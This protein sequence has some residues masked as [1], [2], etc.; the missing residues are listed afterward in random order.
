MEYDELNRLKKTT[1]DPGGLA[2]VTETTRFDE[3]GNPEVTVDP[4]GQTITITFDELN[5]L[6]SKAYAFAPADTARPW[7]YTES[8]EYGYDENGN[9]QQTEEH[10]ASGSSPPDTTL[11]T[12]RAYDG[13]DR[14]TSEIQPL[15]N[16]GTSTVE[17][18]YFR[19]GTRK[20][21]KDP[22][23]S[24]TAYAYDGQNRLKT[25]TTEATGAEPQTTTYTYE[26]DDLLKTVTYPNGVVATHGYDKA[27]RL[28]SVVNAKGGTA[29]SSYL[30]SGTH[31]STGL[32]VSYDANG[33]RLIQ[34]ETNGGTTE[35]TTYGYD[36]LDRLTAVNYPSDSAYPQGRLVSYGY[37]AVGNRVRETEKDLDRRRACGQARAL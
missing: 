15:P 9:L 35:T 6:K 13:L 24:V 32:P 27:D 25:A 22:G 8:I 5:R 16:G 2:L 3:N 18:S 23:G 33:N 21:V 28:L 31:P 7:R 4:K 12:T 36:D 10:V 14:L 26:P 29:L 20:T 19:N 17:Y 1:Q 30:Y 11:T 37:D 34:V